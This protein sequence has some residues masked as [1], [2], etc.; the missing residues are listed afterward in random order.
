MR[1]QTLLDEATP[2]PPRPKRKALE[3]PDIVVVEK[4]VAHGNDLL[5]NLERMA[6]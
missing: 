6:G 3:P 4:H 1:P 2:P 5:I